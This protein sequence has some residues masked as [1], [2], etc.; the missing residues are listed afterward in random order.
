L[1]VGVVGSAELQLAGWEILVV[2]GLLL[3]LTSHSLPG[4]LFLL[5]AQFFPIKKSV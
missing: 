4:L 5:V 1:D 3:I 2:V